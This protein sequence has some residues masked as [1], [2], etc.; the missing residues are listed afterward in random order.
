ME[1]EET[2]S[3]NVINLIVKNDYCI[4]CGM[5]AGLCPQHKLSMCFN[6]NGECN[7]SGDAPCPRSCSFCLK[8]CPF[9]YENPDEDSIGKMFFSKTEGINFIAEAGYY[10][11]SYAAHNSDAAQRLNSASGGAATW[12]VR[13]LLKN[14]LV[15]KVIAVSPNDDPERLFRYE[16][17]ENIDS[18]MKTAGSYYYPVEVS[19]VLRSIMS[20]ECRYAIVG[21]PCFI[22]AI[23]LGMGQN[24]AL[25]K[26]VVF[27]IGLTCGQ[28][29]GKY[30][31]AYLASSAGIRYRLKSVHYRGKDK[32]RPS[33][34]YYFSCVDVNGNNGKIFCNDGFSLAWGYRWFTPNACNFCDDI[35]AE[36]ADVVFMDAWLPQYLSDYRGNNLVISRNAVIDGIIKSGLSSGELNGGP[37]AITEVLRS[38]EG[39]I[40]TKRRHLA[41]RLFKNRKKPCLPRKRVPM[42]NRINIIE[43]AQVIL[44]NKM[45]EYSKR[46]FR[47]SHSK[48]G[49]FI[50]SKFKIGMEK[51][52]YCM[53]AL[54][55]LQRSFGLP[56]RI[57]TKKFIYSR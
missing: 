18:A 39:V 13:H 14:N 33:S 25:R 5:C 22:K 41:Y 8:V 45:Q 3:R 15:D 56:A 11:N 43:K 7:P 47:E 23:R 50:P 10:L 49:S 17:F 35:F 2:T 30:Y 51:Y 1:T 36:C 12:L 20:K 31:T 9:Y 37:I 26:R 4:G 46:L 29:K 27:T 57:L 55:F 21:L 38:Q 24:S 32:S 48:D 54:D 19:D 42:T 44:Q 52:R 40:K 28:A 53:A 16:V 34:N 6:V